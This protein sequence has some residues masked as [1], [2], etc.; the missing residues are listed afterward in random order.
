ME[1]IYAANRY[2]SISL[3]EKLGEEF[4][5]DS[6]KVSQWFSNRRTQSKDQVATM[7]LL[8]IYLTM[9]NCS[10]KQVHP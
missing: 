10:L 7:S 2:P 5:V 1:T 8:R 9:R 3:K 4:G 6:A